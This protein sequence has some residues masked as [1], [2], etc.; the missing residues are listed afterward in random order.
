[1]TSSDQL[2][3]WRLR[4]E[5]IAGELLD[6]AAGARPVEVREDI[7][8]SLQELDALSEELLDAYVDALR[9]EVA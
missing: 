6:S 8:E 5:E 2:Y 1:M 7:G 9:M 3:T 4:L